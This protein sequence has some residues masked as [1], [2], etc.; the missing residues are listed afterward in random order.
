M[1]LFSFNGRARRSEWWLSHIIYSII[2]V[3]AAYAS[4]YNNISLWN[5][6]FPLA[7][8]GFLSVVSFSVRRLHDLNLPS[9]IMA[10]NFIPYL[11]FIILTIVLGFMPPT[12]INNKYGIDPRIKKDIFK[13]NKK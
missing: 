9:T 11:G 13:S 3:N 1:K 12:N 4:H 5:I 2:L 10:I 8:I 7:I 6:S